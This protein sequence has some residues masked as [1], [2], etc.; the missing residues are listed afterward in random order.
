MREGDRDHEIEDRN[1]LMHGVF[2]FPGARLHL[3]ETGTHDHLDVLA[4]EAARGAA[5][6]HRRVA[7][8]EHD[9]AL[10]DLVDM[11]ERNV[12]KPVD[13][14]VNVAGGFLAT[15]DFKLAATRRAGADEDRVV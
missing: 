2:F 7:A 1:V 13:T 12:G 6:I 9:H 11:A 5:A 4:A 8:A 15:G 14:D 10:A 3:L